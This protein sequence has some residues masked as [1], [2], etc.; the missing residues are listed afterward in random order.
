MRVRISESKKLVASITTGDYRN[1]QE[2]TGCH[3]VLPEVDND[4]RRPPEATEHHRTP[5]EAYGF[6]R[7]FQMINPESSFP[8]PQRL[9]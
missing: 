8:V 9:T 5:Q 1:P 3:R 2:A 6:H 7:R 4:H